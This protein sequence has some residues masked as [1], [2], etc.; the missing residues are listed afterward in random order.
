MLT[1]LLIRDFAIIEELALFFGPGLNSL[2]GETG[3]GKSIVIDAL[4]AALGERTGSDV[5]RSGARRAV[6]DA[7]FEF[8]DGVDPEINAVLD[9][10]GVHPDDDRLILSREIGA[11]GRGVA[12]V[13]G[14]QVTV[15]TL[16][17][18]GQ[19]LVDIHGQSEHLSLLRA[20]E[21]L[22]ILDRF[23]GTLDLRSDF[24]ELVRDVRRSRNRIEE[25]ES[26]SRDRAQRAD[27]LRFQ[28]EE[29]AAAELS[30]GE[31][32]ALVNERRLL[33]S[34]GRVLDDA[35]DALALLVGAEL[36]GEAPAIPTLRRAIQLVQEL[37]QIDPAVAPLA[38]RFGEQLYLLEDGAAELRAY[39]DSVEPDPERLEIV[40]DRIDLLQRLKRKYGAT[41]EAVMAFGEAAQA[42]LESLTGGEQ[43]ID[44]L[45]ERLAERERD[46][47]GLAERL[48]ARRTAAASVLAAGVAG[49]I[50][51][52][53]MGRAT[54]TI[55]VARQT[56]DDGLPMPNGEQVAFDESGVDR[57]AFLLSANAGETPKPLGKVASGGE[58]ARIMLAIKSILA[59]SDTTPALV[60]D[61]VD[62]GVGGRSG[63]VVGEK[64]WSLT[65]GHQ[66]IVITHLPQIAA[67]AD[68][69]FRI[70]KREIDDRTVTEVVEIEGWPRVEEIAAMLGGLD[71][72]SAMIESAHE[73]IEAAESWKQQH[74][75]AAG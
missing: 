65:N 64:L 11:N 30:P 49:S 25:I 17:G 18:L 27:L 13:N 41:I 43:D 39:R 37:A 68:R 38:E 14:R 72:T 33:E 16:Q 31:E 3:A 10:A 8:P 56:S 45:R 48:S 75:V 26:G 35:N 36:E 52:L 70:A 59:A 23:A 21:Q 44:A 28:A 74:Q 15:A 9:D 47:A 51:E 50:H 58:T 55:D 34:T 20:D 66:V 60:F 73:L 71:P 1:E 19:R 54:I 2:T 32:D 63:Q 4:G 6:V 24:G 5:V 62:T 40:A 12:R 29:I 53:R 22:L 57:V 69:H 61:E 42:E 67:F 7:V 46:A